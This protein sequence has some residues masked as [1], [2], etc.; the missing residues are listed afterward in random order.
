M[1]N[2][3]GSFGL[4]LFVISVSAYS[5]SL[6]D[7][8][9]NI[10]KMKNLKAKTFLVNPEPLTVGDLLGLCSSFQPVTLLFIWTFCNGMLFHFLL[11]LN[12]CIIYSVEA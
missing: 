10:K 3:A 4:Q 5:Q 6:S 9:E 12:N 2:K 1:G 8:P 11:L 7:T